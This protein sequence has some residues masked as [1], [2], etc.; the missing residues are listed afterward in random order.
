[1]LQNQ[2][3]IINIIKERRSIRFYKSELPDSNI[4]MKILEASIWAPSGKNLQPWKIKLITDSNIIKDISTLCTYSRFVGRAPCLILL[5]L[6]KNISYNYIKDVQSCGML[7]QNIMLTAHAEGLGTCLV[8][9]L[10]E[11]GEN[12]K[13]ILNI[14]D[15]ALE[16]MGVITI[17]HPRGNTPQVTRKKI[18]EFII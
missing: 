2:Y 16:L 15:E 5:Y 10:T 8:G 4:I 11:K 13:N 9:E 1:M 6:D 12:V 7:M 17:G 14:T 3:E 18:S